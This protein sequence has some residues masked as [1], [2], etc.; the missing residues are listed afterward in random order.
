[1]P[2]DRSVEDGSQHLFPTSA[3]SGES[4]NNLFA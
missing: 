2:S 3:P 1:M 4:V